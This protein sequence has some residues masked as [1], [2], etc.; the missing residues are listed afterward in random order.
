MLVCRKCS[1][2]RLAAITLGFTLINAIIVQ[3]GV[4][5]TTMDENRQQDYQAQRFDYRFREWNTDG[6]RADNAWYW[7][8]VPFLL[9]S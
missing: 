1:S 4:Y 6:L 3:G 9:F 2:K 8:T 7:L 5:A